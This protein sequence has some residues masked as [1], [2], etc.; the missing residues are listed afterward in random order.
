MW[1]NAVPALAADPGTVDVSTFA[2]YGVLGVFAVILLWFARGSYQREIQRADRLEEE[3]RKL[4]AAIQDRVL[5]VLMSATNAA[6]ESAEL[7]A[8]MQRERELWRL[9]EQRRLDPKPGSDGGS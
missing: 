2:Q 7:L 8:A 1:R 6:Q 4:N 5:P 9:T 3:N